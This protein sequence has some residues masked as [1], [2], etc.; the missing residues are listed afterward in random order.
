MSRLVCRLYLIKINIRVQGADIFIFF[1][2]TDS[3][4]KNYTLVHIRTNSV[5][6]CYTLNN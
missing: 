3:S 5:R 6:F 4:G 2:T 1:E